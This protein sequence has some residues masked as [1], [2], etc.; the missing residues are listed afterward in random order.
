MGG[1]RK[2]DNNKQNKTGS[3]VARNNIISVQPSFL[4][5]EVMAFFTTNLQAKKEGLLHIIAVTEA[6]HIPP[7]LFPTQ[8]IV[9]VTTSLP[10]RFW[11]AT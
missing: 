2:C 11:R 3:K 9:D 5:T 6:T 7:N 8:S 1:V 4:N 10:L